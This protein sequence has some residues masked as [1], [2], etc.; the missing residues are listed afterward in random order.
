VRH[1][2]IHWRDDGH[3]TGD[4]AAALADGELDDADVLAHVA[5]CDACL[6]AVGTS[7]IQT[8]EVGQLL[9]T[10]DHER[11]V[12]VARPRRRVSLAASL[13]MTAALGVAAFAVGR[14]SAAD[15]GGA[16]EPAAAVTSAAFAGAPPSLELALVDGSAPPLESAFSLRLHQPGAQDWPWRMGDCVTRSPLR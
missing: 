10:M 12:A 3:L 5:G 16:P 15:G 11:V 1:P 9:A 14:L 2:R 6:Q 7:A 13:A 8:A 4:A